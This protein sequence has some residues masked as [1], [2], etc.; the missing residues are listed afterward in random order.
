M[1]HHTKIEST[2]DTL[3]N[4]PNEAS[5]MVRGPLTGLIPGPGAPWEGGG[6]VNIPTSKTHHQITEDLTR[7][8]AVGPA[9][10]Y[11]FA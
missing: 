8:W 3:K 2:I 4:R 5:K 6:D 11:I 9:N 10:F 7:R 1:Q